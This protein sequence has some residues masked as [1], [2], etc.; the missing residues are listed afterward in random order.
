MHRHRGVTLLELLVVMSI[1]ALLLGFGVPSFISNVRSSQMSSSVNAF[2]SDMRYARSMAVRR[3]ASVVMCRVNKL[4]D[5]A[6]PVCNTGKTIDVD[7]DGLDDGWAGGWFVFED[8]NG[9]SAFN[10]G[11]TVLRF[12]SKSSAI[13]SIMSTNKI[14]AFNFTATGR[15]RTVG[16]ATTL[17]FGGPAYSNSQQRVVCVSMSGHV[18]IAGDGLSSCS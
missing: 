1:T 18:R 9:N 5:D 3:S 6:N 10:S 7:G 17:T 15:L 12:Q 4:D 8:A 11:E 2:L 14:N 16:N 13:G